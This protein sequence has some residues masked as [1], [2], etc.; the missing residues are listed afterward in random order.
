MQ[1]DLDSALIAACH[2]HHW[3]SPIFMDVFTY[4]H[5][6]H[7]GH[8]PLLPLYI[9]VR[10]L[11]AEDPISSREKQSNLQQQIQTLALLLSLL[12]EL[13]KEER[14][15]MEDGLKMVN[16]EDVERALLRTQGQLTL[17][18]C[19]DDDDD[20]ID[21]D[22]EMNEEERNMGERAMME[23]IQE[24]KDISTIQDQKLI[25]KLLQHQS[26]QLALQLSRTISMPSNQIAALFAAK[27]RILHKSIHQHP[28]SNPS[29]SLHTC[30]QVC[31]DLFIMDS[32][33]SS[34]CGFIHALLTHDVEYA[35][36][37]VVHEGFDQLCKQ[38]KNV[39]DPVI[40][41]L[42]QFGRVEDSLVFV[43]NMMM[44]IDDN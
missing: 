12:R 30:E 6:S 19:D 38:G 9:R 43:W 15:I 42:L 16:E 20:V 27:F 33:G 17:L 1:V 29:T 10:K 25:R 36:P 7:T 3:S 4:F 41:V 23:E 21:V 24:E 2:A 44:I 40:Q 13:P 28:S 35:I 18:M 31:M 5:A 37:T 39:V 32:T 8:L 11:L 22:E 34:L 26:Y 14:W